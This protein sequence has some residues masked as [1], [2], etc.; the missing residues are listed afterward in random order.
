MKVEPVEHVDCNDRVK[1]AVVAIRV[2]VIRDGGGNCKEFDDRRLGESIHE[3]CIMC[4][5]VRH[6]KYRVRHTKY[7]RDESLNEKMQDEED[8]M[9]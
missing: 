8:E 6:M 3:A 5:A 7:H 4:I 1:D 9:L 2:G